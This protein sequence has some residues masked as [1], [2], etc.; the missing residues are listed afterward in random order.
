MRGAV[1]PLPMY[2]FMERRGTALRL[3]VSSEQ[4]EQ[5]YIIIQY[6]ALT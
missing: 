1:F 3:H 2:A 4:V 5:L 6:Y